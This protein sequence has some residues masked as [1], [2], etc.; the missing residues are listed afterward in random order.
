MRGVKI[1]KKAT[2]GPRCV[3]DPDY[4]NYCII[5]E[6]ATLSGYNIILCHNQ[7][8]NIHKNIFESFVAPTIIGKNADLAIGVIVLPGVKIGENSVIG[9]G[10]VVTKDIPPNCLAVGIPAKVIREYKVKNGIPIGIKSSN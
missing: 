2:I 4:P 7:P 1:G 10:A 3:I 8:L 6:G 9:A 5:E